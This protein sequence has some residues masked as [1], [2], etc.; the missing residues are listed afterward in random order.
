MQVL[1]GVLAMLLV[2]FAVVQYNDADGAFWAIGYSVGAFW[3]AM[4]AFARKRLSRKLMRISL[5]ATFAGVVLGV[6]AFWPDAERWWAID[7]W[8][9]EVSGET[10]R[11][12]M[13]MMVLAL[14][15]AVA[16]F[17]GWRR[18]RS[19]QGENLSERM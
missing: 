18:G 19:V 4:A 16:A 5:V 3:C 14:A 7:V 1:C 12:G 17:V 9:P 2:A 13:G 6:V 8:W 11:E 10:S 15:T